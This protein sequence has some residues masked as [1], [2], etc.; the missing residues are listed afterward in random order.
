MQPFRRQTQ[1][2]AVALCAQR[3]L[4]STPRSSLPPACRQPPRWQSLPR[5]RPMEGG[6]SSPDPNVHC[7]R[8][9]RPRTARG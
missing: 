3:L 7:T 5:R 6:D 9:W 4:R 8:R 2:R 1:R